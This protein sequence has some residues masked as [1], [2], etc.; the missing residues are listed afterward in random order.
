[1]RPHHLTVRDAAIEDLPACLELWAAMRSRSGRIDRL[2]PAPST[3]VG[4]S[5]LAEVHDDPCRRIVV[6]QCGDDVV[7]MA[8]LTRDPL[9][10]LVNEPAVQLSYA[11]VRPDH[12]RRGVGRALV[13]ASVGYADA[14]G[15]DYVLVN[16]HPTLR[17]SNR[18]FARLGFTPL[19]VRRIAPTAA[20][21]R[22]LGL[23][24]RMS[25]VVGSRRRLLRAGRS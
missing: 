12:R 20:L 19:F 7:G 23:D 9:A 21:R 1:M 10:P 22:R 16:V 11:V 18:F 15:A 13:A 2:F 3:E 4:R 25:E 5:L 24:A 6:A 17:E 8:V 14:V